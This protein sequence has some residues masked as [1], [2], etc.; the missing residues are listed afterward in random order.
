MIK[1]AIFGVVIAGAFPASLYMADARYVM[2]NTFEKSV[3][4]QRAWDLQD[5]IDEIESRAEY[6]SRPKTPYENQQIKQWEQQM[7][8]LGI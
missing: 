4:Q 5:R 1:E 8:R 3:K 6:E 7:R 2:Q